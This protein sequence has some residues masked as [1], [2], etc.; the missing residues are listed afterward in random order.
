MKIVNLQKEQ[1]IC[2]GTKVKDHKIEKNLSENK[3][4]NLQG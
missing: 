3:N 2:E 1:K 4:K